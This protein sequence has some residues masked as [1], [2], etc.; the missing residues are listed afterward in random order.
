MPIKTILLAASILTTVAMSGQAA[1]AYSNVASR[2]VRYE[3]TF[4]QRVSRPFSGFNQT[5]WSTTVGGYRYHGGPK[6]D[7]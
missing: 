2:H 7:D 5:P 6:S 3:T 4:D 1:A